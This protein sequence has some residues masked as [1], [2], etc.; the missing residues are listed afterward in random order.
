MSADRAARDHTT[1]GHVTHL[2]SA[3]VLNRLADDEH[4]HV[5]A[6]LADCAMC[7]DDYALAM[8]VVEGADRQL[9]AV[10]VPSFALLDR[11]WSE[12]DAPAPRAA[13]IAS[14]AERQ[15]RLLWRLTRAQL[16]L[17]PKGIWVA[18]AATLFIAVLIASLWRD[19]AFPPSLLGLLL[20]PVAAAGVAF[21][22][23]QDADPGLEIALATPTSPRMTL[24]CRF[25]LVFG[26]NTA[27]ALGGALFLAL[28]HHVEFALLTSYWFGPMLLLASLGLALTVRFGAFVGAVVI[29][30]LWCLRVLGLALAPLQTGPS[31][32]ILWR[33]SPA[34][35]LCAIALLAI[36]AIMLPTE[37]N[38]A[39]DQ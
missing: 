19:G 25:L 37:I 10:P 17:L 18:S 29:G 39:K 30:A 27:L 22:G 33:T 12:I 6:H 20:A 26:Y 34:L 7:R 3:Y 8:A 16:P 23:D 28:A 2:L 1:D 32:P 31:L 36:A 4:Q 35:V 24:F 21:L 38:T 14:A 15:T 11:V 5:Q 9:Q 13:L